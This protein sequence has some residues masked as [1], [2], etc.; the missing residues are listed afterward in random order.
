MTDK[1]R[2]ELKTKIIQAISKT[3]EDVIRREESAKPISPDNAIGRVSRMDAIN[4][5]GVAEAGL[6]STKRKLSNLKIALTKIDL[7][8]F[9]HCSHCSNPIQ[10]ARLMFMPQSDKCV[11]C[12]DK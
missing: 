10:A 7:P 8:N 4:N 1:E 6:Q 12:A 11:R 9:G 2:A 5:R 3:E